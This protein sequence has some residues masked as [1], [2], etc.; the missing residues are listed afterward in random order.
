M[1]TS[2]KQSQSGELADQLRKQ[3]RYGILKP[4]MPLPSIRTLSAENGIGRQIVLSAFQLLA[5]EGLLLCAVGRG[6]LVNPDLKAW[7]QCRIAFAVVGDNCRNVFY[8]SISKGLFRATEGSGKEIVVYE[9]VTSEQL[10]TISADCIL[11]SGHVTRHLVEQLEQRNQRCIVIGNYLSGN[12]FNQIRFGMAQLTREMLMTD[13]THTKEVG[14][15]T[16]SAGYAVSREM[17]EELELYS[18]EFDLPWGP[19]NAVCA[20][21]PA[22]VEEIHAVWG[23]HGFPDRIVTTQHLYSGLVH[24]FKEH[25]TVQKR[26]E[27]LVF[28]S[29]PSLLPLSCPGCQTRVIVTD[30]SSCGPE[31]LQTTINYITGRLKTGFSGEYDL[32]H[33]KLQI[34]SRGEKK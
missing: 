6:T 30:E 26:P 20:Y 34:E 4:G 33:K 25:E 22:G 5:D 19:K 21:T 9:N 12:W 31:L 11:L 17:I 7:R 24:Y 27:I 18:H 2:R 29:D 8:Q 15:L 23:R 32:L 1:I 16:D 28:L 13:E 14:I 3:I 10:K